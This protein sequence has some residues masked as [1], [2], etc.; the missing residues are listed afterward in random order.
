MIWHVFMYK[1][2]YAGHKCNARPVLSWPRLLHPCSRGRPHDGILTISVSHRTAAPG[3]LAA[4][5]LPAARFCV[6]RWPRLSTHYI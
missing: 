5:T 6:P 4:L 1:K 3:L 2:A